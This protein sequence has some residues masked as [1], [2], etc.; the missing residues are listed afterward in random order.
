MRF[1]IHFG[2][3]ISL[4]AS[5]LP[6]ASAQAPKISDSGIVNAVTY[7][8]NAPVAQGSYAAIF[9]SQLA[10]GI[11]VAASIPLATQLTNV[12]VTFDGVQAPLA[13][14]SDGQINAQ[15]PWETQ[16]GNSTVVVTNNGAK[17]APQ[18]VK[19]GNFSPGVYATTDGHAIAI[20]IV[21][22]VDT[23]N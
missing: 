6:R 16:S 14:V 4:A 23:K 20:N 18:T 19:V 7:D 2:V 1:P 13:F 17:S 9:G 10:A 5:V 11:A 12:S 15:V 21:D 22:G 8:K 3:A